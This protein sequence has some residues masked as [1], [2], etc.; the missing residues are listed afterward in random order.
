MEL[1]HSINDYFNTL[2]GLN[3]WKENNPVALSLQSIHP[4]LES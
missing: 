4:N 3:V 2:K 1:I